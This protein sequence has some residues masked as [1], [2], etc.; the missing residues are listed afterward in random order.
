MGLMSGTSADGVDAVMADFHGHP[1][2]P[3]WKLL[4]LFSIR[5]PKNLQKQILDVGQGKAITAKDFL[6]LSESITKIQATAA[7]KCDPKKQSV[8]IGC[9][10]QTVFHRPPKNKQIGGSLQILQG[11]LLSQL[12]LRPVI[13]DFRSKDLALGGQ[14]APL[15]PLAD[16]A[17]VGRTNGWRALLNLG[18]I[19]NLTLIPPKKGPDSKNS[20]FGWDC[21][22][23]NSLLDL[24]IQKISNNKYCYDLNGNRALGGL[25]NESVIKTWL[26]EP[27]FE[28]MPPKST[29]RKF[30]G[31]QD[32]NNRL[33]DL[34]DFSEEDQLATIT[35]FSAAI[36]AKDLEN[37]YLK[38]LIA[39][40]I[41]LTAGG[42][43]HNLALM[44]EIRQ[45]CKG[46]RVTTIDEIGIPAQAREA[47]AFALLTWWH[48]INFP[49]NS[50]AV[51]GARKKGVL[52]VRAN[53]N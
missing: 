43:I 36:I 40:I 13:Y 38:Q 49:G 21:G 47:L 24:A 9:H 20:V 28:K 6:E 53:P 22:P 31:L 19:S 17:L 12:L 48:S 25:A 5:Y 44:S 14:G 27:F 46:I 26:K 30:F 29:G 37:L 50:P 4:N 10:G 35:A 16:A 15:V 7:H 1:A 42:G 8:L 23:A 33:S 11:Q 18:G 51:T 32:L 39:P 34:S 41:L 3:K 52:G 2:K 45:R